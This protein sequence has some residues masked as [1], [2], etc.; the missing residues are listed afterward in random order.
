MDLGPGFREVARQLPGVIALPPVDIADPTSLSPGGN[1]R[2]CVDG[3]RFLILSITVVCNH[4]MK[5]RTHLVS[6]SRLAELHQRSATK[7][8]KRIKFSTGSNARYIPYPNS[9]LNW[10]TDGY[11]LS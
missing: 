3:S 8:L 1:A 10:H 6:S 9:E 11:L 5:Q 7:G 4:P 2:S